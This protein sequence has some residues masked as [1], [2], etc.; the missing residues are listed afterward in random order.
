MIETNPD[1][2]RLAGVLDDERARRQQR[3]R[4]YGIPV[5]LKDNIDTAIACSRPPARWFSL[6]HPRRAM[7]GRW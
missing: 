2:L 1:A 6:M 5:R 7:P 3:G 4:L